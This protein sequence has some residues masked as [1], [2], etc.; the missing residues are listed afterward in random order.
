MHASFTSDVS[1]LAYTR[2]NGDRPS[3]ITEGASV[4]KQKCIPG[5]KDMQKSSYLI[6]MLN[7]QRV[8]P[9]SPNTS[10]YIPYLRNCAPQRPLPQPLVNI[11]FLGSD[12]RIAKH[13]A[14]YEM[15]VERGIY[16]AIAEK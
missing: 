11:H 6:I 12:T 14:A 15:K 7:Y 4:Q 10:Q 8:H 9:Q 1:P 13:G 3:A 5:A 2:E 16:H